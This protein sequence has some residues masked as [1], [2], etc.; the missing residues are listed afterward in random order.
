MKSLRSACL[1]LSACFSSFA[2]AEPPEQTLETQLRNHPKPV[3][4]FE[5]RTMSEVVPALLDLSDRQ[6]LCK[7]ASFR[8]NSNQFVTSYSEEGRPCRIYDLAFPTVSVS[9]K[10]HVGVIPVQSFISEDY[11]LWMHDETSLESSVAQFESRFVQ[12]NLKKTW[13][14]NLKFKTDKESLNSPLEFSLFDLD[15]GI[16]SLTLQQEDAK[17]LMRLAELPGAPKDHIIQ[18]VQ[19]PDAF[20]EG[21]TLRWNDSTKVFDVLANFQVLP[22]GGPISLVD[23]NVQ[24]KYAAEKLLRSAL[25]NALQYA[26]KFIPE[27]TVRNVVSIAIQDT[28]EFVELQYANEMS[29]LEAILTANMAQTLPTNVAL[30]DVDKAL[31]IL[32]AQR[33]SLVQQYI[34][35]RVLKQNFDLN[36]LDKLGATIRYQNAKTKESLRL[37]LHSD[38]V[39]KKACQTSVV[40]HD[41]A[42]CKHPDGSE[43]LYSLLSSSR[44]F[45][46]DFGAT[47]IH[48]YNARP[49]TANARK[50]AWTLSVAA[51]VM[52]L[53]LPS[54]LSN[55]LVSIAK[56][57]ATGGILDDST[58]L[59]ALEPELS[60]GNPSP[61]AADIA[62]WLRKQNIVPFA[63]KSLEAETRI[64]ELNRARLSSRTNL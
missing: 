64:I 47:L 42:V 12:S 63:P 24:Y 31:N 6:P 43:G 22:L 58:L 19:N 21:I 62:P 28:F 40:F 54:T 52:P 37:R 23:F 1:F 32:T 50:L 46:R 4:V 2:F 56:S 34:L 45:M 55:Q 48:N 18:L 38:L 26:V 30:P 57:Y 51:R 44:F 7:D 36:A 49:R 15:L 53:P 39:T 16:E 14:N 61:F 13:Y 9:A 3:S 27:P 5:Q 41:F 11:S 17:G 60:S 10:N 35:A 59:G 8:S 29:R 20:L 25:L 33:S